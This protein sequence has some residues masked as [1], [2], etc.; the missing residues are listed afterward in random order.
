ME[1]NRISVIGPLNVDLLIIGEAPE[2]IDILKNWEGPADIQLCAAGSIGYVICDLVKLGVDT[3][4]VSTVSDDPLSVS[5]LEQLKNNGIDTGYIRRQSNSVSGIGVY[6]LLFGDRKRPLSYRLPSH[7]PWP[8]TFTEDETEYLLDTNILH[9]GGYLHFPEMYKGAT[10]ELYKEA[11]KRGILTAMDTQFPLVDIKKPWI[12]EMEDIIPY[13]DV[14]FVDEREGACITGKNT[15][16]AAAEILRAAG[17]SIVVV[18]QGDKGSWISTESKSFA[19]PAVCVGQLV[20]SIGAGD[21]FGASF[22]TGLLKKW[23]IK[24]VAEFAATVAG[25]TVTG[26][27][28]TSGMPAMDEVQKYIKNNIR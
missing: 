4:V 5:L 7:E 26:I 1:N 11:K 3:R 25:F 21:A 16:E 27:G 15:P 12:R 8:R 28:G 6:M 19:Q 17:P 2:N 18:K 24:K 20:D 14:L 13:V 10:T 9:C 22:L 23:D